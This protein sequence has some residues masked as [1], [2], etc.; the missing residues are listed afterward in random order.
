MK[1]AILL[2]LLLLS[3]TAFS[4]TSKAEQLLIQKF[5]KIQYWKDRLLTE[6]KTALNDSL[7]SSSEIFKQ[8]L[9]K[10]TRE[11]TSLTDPLTQLQKEGLYIASAKDG[12]FRIYSWDTLTGG[13]MHFFD[14]IYQY[15]QSGKTLSKTIATPQGDAG[16]WYSEIFNFERNGQTYYLGY[17]NAIYSN[18]HCAQSIKLFE[19][20]GKGLHNDV[21]LIQTKTGIKNSLTF[22]FDFF[23][24]V[25]RPE[26]PV[27]LIHFDPK[28]KDIKIPVVLNEGLG[29]VTNRFITYHFNGEY[30][31]KSN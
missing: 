1:K 23:S 13:S 24:V 30:F 12:H 3:L 10:Y 16:G 18:S 7:I 19:I 2:P 11:E 17:F 15:K 27:K 9:L 14:N 20:D 29:K 5:R 6:S 26:R 25:D 4:Q 8:S 21:K 31:V 22:S 28:N